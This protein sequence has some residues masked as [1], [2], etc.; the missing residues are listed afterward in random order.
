MIHTYAARLAWQGSTGD[1]YRTYSR[2]HTA[3]APPAEPT[4]SLTADPGF[5]GD[6]SDLNP[7]QLLLMSTSSCQL[8][9]FLAEAAIR[10]IDVVAYHDS[11]EAF[12]DDT[13][14]PM[15]ITRIVLH[16]V[17]RVAAG[18]D[19]DEVVRLVHR[20]HDVCFIANSLTSTI[21]IEPRI[22]S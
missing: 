3:S 20:A 12:M 10:R 4:L 8:L 19:V 7:E 16:P 13:A 22:E 15:R 1:G 21:E 9:S 5:G 2:A 11:A 14:G 6:A 18:T 17:I